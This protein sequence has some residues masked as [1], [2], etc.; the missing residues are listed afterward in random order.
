[1][2]LI[3]IA[4]I[5]L[6]DELIQRKRF[7]MS[8]AEESLKELKTAVTDRKEEM[9]ESM[10]TMKAVLRQAW[11]ETGKNSKKTNEPPQEVEKEWEEKEIPSGVELIET[12]MTELQAKAD[13]MD[14]IDKRTVR[15]YRELKETIKEL[16][17]DI[18][19]R[20]AAMGESEEKMTL[21]KNSWLEALEALIKKINTIFSSYFSRNFEDRMRKD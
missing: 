4:K 17:E 12:L 7:E 2:Y 8:Q 18:K 16:D 15:E 10:E 6:L 11:D 14:S 1:M 5:E 21:L 3:Y 20:D 19:L 9:D 13:C